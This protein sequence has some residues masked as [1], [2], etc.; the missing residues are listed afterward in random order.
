MAMNRYL[1]DGGKLTEN[2][3]GAWERAQK[4]IDD[5]VS[6]SR[7]FQQPDGSLFDE[8]FRTPCHFG[9]DQST[10]QHHGARISF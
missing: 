3:D 1:E 9:R 7:R 2:A 5:A 10:H 4:K 6:A 8:L